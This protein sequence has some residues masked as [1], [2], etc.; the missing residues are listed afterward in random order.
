ML[1][2]LRLLCLIVILASV[3]PGHKTLAAHGDVAISSP[4]TSI[5]DRITKREAAIA[6][7]AR[8]GHI[9]LVLCILVIAAGAIASVLQLANPAPI[10]GCDTCRV[11]AAVAL[12]SPRDLG[13]A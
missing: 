1:Q 4:W 5:E 8:D 11:A 7:A 10:Q 12:C 6:S 9:N 2:H 13:G 3:S